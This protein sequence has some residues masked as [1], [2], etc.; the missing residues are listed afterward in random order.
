IKGMPFGGG[1]STARDLSKFATALQ[2]EKLLSKKSVERLWTGRVNN[3]QYG[4][5]FEVRMYNNHRIVGHGGGWFG[6]TN[7]MD[8]YPDLGYTVVILS[9]YDT[10]AKPIAMRISEWITAGVK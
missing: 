5:G 9:N 8:I 4:Y 10:Q 3:N 7:H 2:S 6:I 1:Y